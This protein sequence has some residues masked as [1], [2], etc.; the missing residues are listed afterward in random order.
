MG[1]VCGMELLLGL[2][3]RNSHTWVKGPT[4]EFR[5]VG[6]LRLLDFWWR[7]WFVPCIY[8]P[9]TPHAGPNPLPVLWGGWGLGWDLGWGQRLNPREL[10]VCVR[11]LPSVAAAA[12]TASPWSQKSACFEFSAARFRVVAGLPLPPPWSGDAGC[13]CLEAL[14]LATGTKRPGGAQLFPCFF[15]SF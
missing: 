12:V 13:W 6:L 14:E 3:T 5:V 2:G 7:W 4:G 10:C 8:T 15:V 11:R 1:R 9:R